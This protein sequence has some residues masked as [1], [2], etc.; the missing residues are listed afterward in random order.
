MLL[1]NIQRSPLTQP[2]DDWGTVH[3]P[4][5]PAD[6]FQSSFRQT[7]RLAV[8]ASGL[9]VRPSYRTGAADSEWSLDLRDPAKASVSSGPPP[10][11]ESPDLALTISDVNFAKLVAGKLGPQ[12]VRAAMSC[13]IFCA[14]TVPTNCV[15]RTEDDRY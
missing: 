9:R 11:G 8:A 6:P 1:F 2:V 12:Q 15:Y 13:R 7:F 10:E 3:G 4:I 14:F 5:W